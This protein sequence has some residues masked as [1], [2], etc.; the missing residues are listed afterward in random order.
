MELIEALRGSRALE[1]IRGLSY[2][3][4]NGLHKHNPERM[5]KPPDAFPWY[6]YHRLPVEKYILPSFFGRR[7]AVHHMSIGCPFR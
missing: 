5:M 6:P 1:S 4:P 3:E 7:T 2:K